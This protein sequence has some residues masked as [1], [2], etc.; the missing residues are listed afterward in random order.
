VL[1][2][3]FFGCQEIYPTGLNGWIIY[4]FLLEN[5]VYDS[6]TLRLHLTSLGIECIC[7]KEYFKAFFLSAKHFQVAVSCLAGFKSIVSGHFCEKQ[8]KQGESKGKKMSVFNKQQQKKKKRMLLSK[9]GSKS[10]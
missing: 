3:I 1:S 8:H 10:M 7:Q 4:P 2:L 5:K 6:P 9:C